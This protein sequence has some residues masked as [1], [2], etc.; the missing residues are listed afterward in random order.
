MSAKLRLLAAATA[1]LALAG[2]ASGQPVQ[3]PVPATPA[4]SPESAEPLSAEATTV[5]TL[6]IV[7]HLPGPALW[8]VTKGDSQV[9]ILGGLTPLPHML[10]WDTQRIQRALTGADALYLQPRPRLG[11]FEMIGLAITKRALQ[12]P[13]GQT[14]DKVLPPAERAR[15]LAL[16]ATIHKKPGDYAHWKPAVAGLLLIADFRKAAGLSEGKPGTTVM[17]LAKDARVPVRYVG[18]FDLGPYIKTTAT[19]SPAANLACFDAALDDIDQEA[20]HSREASDAWAR[21][22][23]KTVGENYRV[24]VLDRCLLQVPSVQGLVEKGTSIGVK[25][26]EAAL[27]KPGKSVAVIDLNFLLRRGGILDRL[28]A[29]GA[30]LSVPE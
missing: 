21:G 28:K 2:A 7:K 6:D 20:A 22:D 16:T 1:A 17:H 8:K 5:A 26:I 19:L 18:D 12:L 24:S 10:A 25:T 15:F 4:P 30:T 13:G 27:A 3:A 14:L 9:V 11:V 23:L 29:E